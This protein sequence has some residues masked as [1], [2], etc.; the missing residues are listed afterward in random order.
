MNTAAGQQEGE[1]R[2]EFL[3]TYLDRLRQEIGE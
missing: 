3:Q 1:R 2:A